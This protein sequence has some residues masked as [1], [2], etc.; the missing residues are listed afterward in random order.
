[1]AILDIFPNTKGMALV[2][3]KKHYDSYAFDMSDEAYVNLMIASKKVAKILEKRLPVKRVGMI[4]EGM[5]QNHV[6]IKMYPLHGLKNSYED[7]F[8]SER[9]YFEKYEGYITSLLGPKEVK[10]AELRKLAEQL[11]QS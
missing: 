5:G 1:M 4:M 10:V 3:S 2:I 7:I 9:I 6:H 11:K 8:A